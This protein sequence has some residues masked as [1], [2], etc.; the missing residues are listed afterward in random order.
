MSDILMENFGTD[1]TVLESKYLARCL[2]TLNEWKAPTDGWECMDV[3]DIREDDEDVPLTTCELC[4]C[5]KVRYIH[6]MRNPEY[7]RDIDVGCI[8]AGIMEG[9]IL[10]AK[11]RERLI[12]NRSGRK[13]RFPKRKW[14]KDGNRWYLPYKG[15][16]I[17]IGRRRSDPTLMG[18]KY[19][20]RCVWTYRGKPIRNFLSAV[21]AAFDL[22]DPLPEVKR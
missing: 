14:L 15:D 18:V 13:R 10:A 17:C 2:R 4:G 20:D 21:Y 12:R 5:A 3:I 7:D 8:C 9:D 16:E 6:L 1:G 19:N 11:E 22:V